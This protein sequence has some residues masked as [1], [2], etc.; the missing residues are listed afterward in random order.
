MAVYTEVPVPEAHALALRLNLGNLL[1]LRGIKGGI[2]NSN[3]F[4]S[5]E[6]GEFVLTLFERLDPAQLPFYL[7]L[8][9]HLAQRGVPAP[10]PQA[11]AHGTLL[12][13]VCGKPAAVVQ[14]LRGAHE[15]RPGPVHCAELGRLL[16]RMHRAVA[17]F[18]P[19]QPNLRGVDWWRET[20]PLLL[21]LVDAHCRAL[22]E[23]ELD[24]QLR[25]AAT[26]AAAALPRGAIHADVFR[27]N[28]MFE[29]EQ[30]TG[31]FDFYFAG[32]DSFLFDLAVALNDWCIDL[33]SGR[34][35]ETRADALV[36]AYETV[37]PLAGAERRA[38]PTVLRAAAF[39]FW[40]SRLADLYRPRDAA[41]LQAHDPTHFERVLR[42]R[43]ATP[44]HADSRN[45]RDS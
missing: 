4:L 7:A 13:H 24:H 33:A 20:V 45:S 18:A 11:D 35:D 5:C 8:M 32:V 17:D 37:R 38:L 28:V 10:E 16:A 2:E 14:R 42:E 6:R 22:L 29:G 1:D 43:I 19:V 3:Y 41:L 15:M 25:F 34:L 40:L 31:I 27:D 12:H 9:Q 23:S 39:R 30:L 44:W 21:P 36:A 26:P